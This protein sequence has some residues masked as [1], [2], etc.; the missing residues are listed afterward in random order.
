MTP[1]EYVY[2]L[3]V[4]NIL[5]TNEK[6]A[7]IEGVYG[8]RRPGR[9]WAWAYTILLMEPADVESI[10]RRA[11]E[12]DRLL[13][14]TLGVLR[15]AENLRNM[16]TI[17]RLVESGPICRMSMEEIAH[18]VIEAADEYRKDHAAQNRR[19][20]KVSISEFEKAASE[21]R[22]ALDVILARV[23]PEA[24]AESPTLARLA[25]HLDAHLCRRRRLMVIAVR[26]ME[27]RDATDRT[28]EDAARYKSKDVSD[29]PAAETIRAAVFRRP[30]REAVLASDQYLQDCAA[31]WLEATGQKCA[32][33]EIG[34]GSKRKGQIADNAP[35]ARYWRACLRLIGDQKSSLSS[36]KSRLIRLGVQGR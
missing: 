4:A 34:G 14:R 31:I 1:A 3:R 18:G 8:L 2:A 29:D 30:G 20:E 33:R 28:L 23:G 6:A 26:L 5:R 9:K 32:L 24:D 15:F 36:I 16:A 11:T 10:E 7:A 17:S 27:L 25:D 19:D 35:R 12:H 13:P 22:S 21:L